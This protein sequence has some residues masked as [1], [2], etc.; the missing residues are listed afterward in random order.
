[1]CGPCPGLALATRPR[2]AFYTGGDILFLI[3]LC[4]LS[5]LKQNSD[6]RWLLLLE[7][8]SQGCY[9]SLSWNIT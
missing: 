5:I 6:A 8:T 1:M 2:L 7:G 4:F 9:K 3:Y